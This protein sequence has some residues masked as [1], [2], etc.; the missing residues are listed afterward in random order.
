MSFYQGKKF[1]VTEH[2]IF[3]FFLSW[4]LRG[5]LSKNR[6]LNF[7][8]KIILPQTLASE[9][10]YWDYKFA[11][12]HNNFLATLGGAEYFVP[13]LPVCTSWKLKMRHFLW[14]CKM[15]DLHHLPMNFIPLIWGDATW[16]QTP[17]IETWIHTEYLGNTKQRRSTSTLA[18]C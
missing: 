9:R 5:C 1:L 14:C 8:W 7:A 15:F 2:I 10:L 18:E 13:P 17:T 11:L 12:I 6:P 16:M 3:P 4:L